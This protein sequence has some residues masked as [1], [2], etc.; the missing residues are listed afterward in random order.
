MNPTKQENEL[1]EGITAEAS[2]SVQKKPKSRS[3]LSYT[4]EFAIYIALILLCVFWI[5]EHVLQRTVVKGESMENTLHTNESLLVEKV[6]YHF[7]KPSRYDIIVFYPYGKSGTEIP[8]SMQA[9]V[10]IDNSSDDENDSELYV[11]RVFGLPGEKIQIV[12]NDILVNG[13][14]IE[15]KY[16]KNVMKDEDAGVASKEITLGEDEYF[17][18]GDNREVSLDSRELGPIKEKNIAGHVVL[19]IWPLNKFGTP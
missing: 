11:K 17:V 15:D 7:T 5:P 1:E 9:T 6:S 2:D 3:K 14:K 8:A 10:D 19:R 12:G 18:L 16:A 13:K 4:I